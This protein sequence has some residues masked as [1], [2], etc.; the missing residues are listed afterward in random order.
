MAKIGYEG[1]KI[2]RK[3]WIFFGKL[4]III[5]KVRGKL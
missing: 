4:C 5:S 2:S 1:D 3:N